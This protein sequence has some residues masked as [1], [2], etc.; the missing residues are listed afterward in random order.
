MK[1]KLTLCLFI[2][3][4]AMLLSPAAAKAAFAPEP[5]L[6]AKAAV[7]V[8][9]DD[10]SLLY[11]KNE[12]EKL[13]IASTTKI[14]TSLLTLEAASSDNRVIAVTPEMIRVEGSSM[15]LRANDRL[16]L[17]DLACGML[18]V[19]GNDAANAAAY[20]VGGTPEKFAAMMNAKAA[21]LGMKDTNFVTPSGLDDDNHYS[22]AYDM[23][24]LACAA[25]ENGNFAAIVRQK[26]MEIRFVNPDVTHYY[27]NHNKLL[28]LDPCCT[29]I[30]TGFTRKAG[31]CLVSSAEKNGVR[32]IVVTLNDPNDWDDHE[33]LFKYGF[34]KLA[35]NKIDDSS[36]RISE[37]VV[38]GVK[39]SAAVAGTSGNDVVTGSGET[40]KRSVEL[41]QFVYAPIKAGQV[42]G[43][44]RYTCGGK[45][46]AKTELTAV[47]DV[48]CLYVKKNLLQQFWDS[49]HRL[50]PFS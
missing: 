45:T 41:P 19:S 17:R 38:G 13:A 25:M 43:C 24:R 23:S 14:M 10:G 46:L 7:V 18:M 2:L 22:T 44:V 5:K 16:T 21:E 12:H 47:E 1:G 3:A 26:S 8:N 37:A 39:D 31:R 27:G 20:A 29:G 6:S 36:M 4:A 35:C 11:A 42:L 30:K 50:F 40:L 15:G 32:I 34:S 28:R 48:G 49:I 33:T 9:A